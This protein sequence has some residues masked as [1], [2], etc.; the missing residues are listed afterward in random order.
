M[1]KLLL[2]GILFLF[3]GFCFSQQTTNSTVNV[4]LAWNGLCSPLI[5][6][7]SIFFTT[8]VLENGPITNIGPALVDDCGTNRSA[9]TNIYFGSYSTNQ[10]IMVL[11][12]TNVTCTI[13]NLVRGATYYFTIRTKTDIMESLPSNE[14]KYTIPFVTNPIPSIVQ[15]LRIMIVN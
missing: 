3:S 11:G 7:Y 2:I 4:N 14:V 1:K 6:G 12:R 15:G 8:N 13:S 10:S 9:Y 5:T